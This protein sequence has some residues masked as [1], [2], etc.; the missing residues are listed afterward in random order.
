MTR[1]I[2]QLINHWKVGNVKV[3]R[4]VELE[5]MFPPFAM[6]ENLTEDRVKSISWL[7][8]HYASPEGMVRYSVQAYVVESQGK[9]IIVDTSALATTK[10]APMKA[11][12]SSNCLFSNG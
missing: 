10:H 3:A 6:F 5:G 2:N 9:R 11:G 4:I 12:T 1:E 7:H 8:P